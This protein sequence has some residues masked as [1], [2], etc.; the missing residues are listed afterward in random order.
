MT[1]IGTTSRTLLP[2]S[3]DSACRQLFLSSANGLE[4]T[5]YRGGIVRQACGIHGCRGPT[6]RRSSAAVS[7]S[8]RTLV[9]TSTSARSTELRQNWKSS[10]PGATWSP[11]WAP[12]STY[13]H[14]RTEDKTTSQKQIAHWC[15]RR[16]SDAAAHVLAVL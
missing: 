3:S 16:G 5:S 9:H 4:P 2:S 11:V 13:S 8:A 1:V 12:A 7:I 6:C 10:V 15:A 14:I